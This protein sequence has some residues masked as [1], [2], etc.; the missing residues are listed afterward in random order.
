VT[1]SSKVVFMQR[2][3][4]QVALISGFKW[5]LKLSNVL[6]IR[7]KSTAIVVYT[8]SAWLTDAIAVLLHPRM[9]HDNS[10]S[11]VVHQ[12]H[13]LQSP[14]SMQHHRCTSRVSLHVRQHFQT[15]YARLTSIDCW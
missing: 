12:S 10:S 14:I 11:S 4:R 1:I 6:A 5:H 15:V 2:D 8:N 9:N 3:F 13:F 7:P